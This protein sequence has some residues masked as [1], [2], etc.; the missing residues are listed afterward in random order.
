MLPPI[1]TPVPWPVA[2]PTSLVLASEVVTPEIF[3]PTPLSVS[4]FIMVF[5]SEALPLTVTP[6]P[7][8]PDPEIEMLLI[9][10]LSPITIPVF[11]PCPVRLTPPVTPAVLI[12]LEVIPIPFSPLAIPDMAVLPAPDIVITDFLSFPLSALYNATPLP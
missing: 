1:L 2:L 8:L 9:S 5:D 11:P 7:V 6:S 12:V 4:P 3:I 10:L